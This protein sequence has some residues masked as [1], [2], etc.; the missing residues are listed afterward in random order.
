[1]N[2][3]KKRGRP[4]KV[5]TLD[6]QLADAVK[7]IPPEDTPVIKEAKERSLA[8]AYAMRVWDGQSP[9]AERGWRIQRVKDALEG[10]GMSFEGV[11]LP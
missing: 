6:E 9:D 11:E 4:P 5:R 7:A 8:Q 10:Q 1:M 3:P 2:E